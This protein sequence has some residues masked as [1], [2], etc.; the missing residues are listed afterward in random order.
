MLMKTIFI[1]LVLYVLFHVTAF[2][3]NESRPIIDI[4]PG[5]EVA[6]PALITKKMSG[7]DSLSVIQDYR[8]RF[9]NRVLFTPHFINGADLLNHNLSMAYDFKHFTLIPYNQR[10]FQLGI[11]DI[12]NRGSILTWKANK[13]LSFSGNL[14][15]SREYGYMFSSRHTSLGLGM[16]M[17]YQLNSQFALNLWGQ[18]LFNPNK[19]PFIKILDTHPQTGMGLNI[20]YNP[21]KNTTLGIGAGFQESAFDN[22]KLNFSVEFK[23]SVK[24]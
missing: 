14:F 2:A 19:D 4:P 5:K 10:F 3:Q 24:F 16:R 22:D 11:G 7:T 1:F 18:Y 21:N 9:D 23:V 12:N 20:E 8:D 13:K 17:K 15:L 6:D